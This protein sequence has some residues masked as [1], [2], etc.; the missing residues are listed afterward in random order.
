MPALQEKTI[1]TLEERLCAFPDMDEEE[2]SFVYFKPKAGPCVKVCVTGRGAVYRCNDKP[3]SFSV[4]PAFPEVKP[5]RPELKTK[6]PEV[7]SIPC[8]VKHNHGS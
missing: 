3:T 6:P 1:C 5:T 4:N 8:D 7:K 2:S